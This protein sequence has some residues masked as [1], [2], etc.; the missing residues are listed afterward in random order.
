VTE[1]KHTLALIEISE[2]FIADVQEKIMVD[3][4]VKTTFG[5]FLDAFRVVYQ[6]AAG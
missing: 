5:H 2:Q 6:G 4:F 1:I 3:G